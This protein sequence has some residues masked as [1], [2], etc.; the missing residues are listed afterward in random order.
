MAGFESRA[1]EP[2][3]T[4]ASGKPERVFFGRRAL[5]DPAKAAGSVN[6]VIDDWQTLRIKTALGKEFKHTSQISLRRPKR[7]PKWLYMWL[8]RSIV[9]STQ[10]IVE[11]DRHE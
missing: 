9:I 6:K 2:P 8:L 4:W 1:V 10:P 7:M 11:Y 3:K 5:A